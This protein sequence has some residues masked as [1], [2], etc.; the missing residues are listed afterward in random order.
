MKTPQTNVLIS[1]FLVVESL[2]WKCLNVPFDGVIEALPQGSSRI[3]LGARR[4]GSERRW[5]ANPED[6]GSIPGLV[7]VFLMEAEGE[8]A[9]VARFRRKSEIPRWSK[10]IRSPPLRRDS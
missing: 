8:N 10:L 1:L 7:A 5:A 9:L 2:I 6:T 4:S 3:P